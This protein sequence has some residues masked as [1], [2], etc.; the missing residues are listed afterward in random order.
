MPSSLF[1]NPRII[2]QSLPTTA[3]QVSVSLR[4]G[5]TLTSFNMVN[6][7]QG[8]Q[9]ARLQVDATADGA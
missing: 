7:S 4:I 2:Q 8:Q 9:R 6:V 1:L 5:G 3:V